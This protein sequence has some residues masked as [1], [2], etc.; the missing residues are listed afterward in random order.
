[1]TNPRF[2]IAS[3]GKVTRDLLRAPRIASCFLE[4]NRMQEVA[5]EPINLF[6]RPLE[7]V[8]FNRPLTTPSAW[9][10]HRCVSDPGANPLMRPAHV[11][12][13]DQLLP[14]STD[15]HV[16]PTQVC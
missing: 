6:A 10:R 5:R 4:D 14:P 1:M 3:A 11:G 13:W 2:Q 16:S 8:P 7:A 12:W 15:N 9:L